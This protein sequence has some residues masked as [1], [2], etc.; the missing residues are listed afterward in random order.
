M[1]AYF[2]NANLL[3]LQLDSG[4]QLAEKIIAGSVMCLL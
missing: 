4:A 1:Y 3:C 2:G